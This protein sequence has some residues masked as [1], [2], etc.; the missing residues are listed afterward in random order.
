MAT[1]RKS[2]PHVSGKILVPPLPAPSLTHCLALAGKAC[3]VD[4]AMKTG[5]ES[6]RCQL[7]FSR[8][9]ILLDQEKTQWLSKFLLIKT[10]TE[11]T[12]MNTLPLPHHRLQPVS[13][14]RSRSQHTKFQHGSQETPKLLPLRRNWHL[15]NALP[16]TVSTSKIASSNTSKVPLFSGSGFPFLSVCGSKTRTLSN[17]HVP[18]LFHSI[19]A[20][21]ISSQENCTCVFLALVPCHLLLS[22]S[23]VTTSS[24]TESRRQILHVNQHALCRQPRHQIAIFTIGC[25]SIANMSVDLFNCLSATPIL[26]LT[27]PHRHTTSGPHQSVSL[28]KSVHHTTDLF[29]S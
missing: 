26:R 29:N 10:V 16:V 14:A 23:R 20:L 11:V 2:L 6:I 24:A 27:S 7:A 8:S 17:D 3:I 4:P 9:V 18:Q 15:P 25:R 13:R 28:M 12:V 22:F 21:C 5:S 1:Q 19:H